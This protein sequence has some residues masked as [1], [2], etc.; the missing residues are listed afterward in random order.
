[1]LALACARPH[2]S[3]LT[4]SCKRSPAMVFKAGFDNRGISQGLPRSHQF[5]HQTA[6]RT[7][8]KF[9]HFFDTCKTKLDE[10]VR[11]TSSTITAGVLA[12]RNATDFN[13]ICERVTRTS[14]GKLFN[15]QGAGRP[16]R[17]GQSR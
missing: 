12:V 8:G 2:K 7:N 11:V 3:S 5:S 4:D 15:C 14:K 17:R 1:M 10:N 9:E 6:I 16:R 13:A